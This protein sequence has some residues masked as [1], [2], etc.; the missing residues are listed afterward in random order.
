MAWVEKD[1]PE[2]FD[3][4]PLEGLFYLDGDALVR[5]YPNAL[6]AGY[7]LPMLAFPSGYECEIW[8]MGDL[9]NGAM[10][11]IFG[12]MNLPL[13][14]SRDRAYEQAVA[15]GRECGYLTLREGEDALDIWGMDLREHYR[16]TY[17]QEQKR[18]VNVEWLPLIPT[19]G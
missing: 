11:H 8:D 14:D 3:Q 2:P 17:D 10:V 19:R 13:F 18:I 5:H 15:I 7:K 4:Q 12:E 9:K 16:I 1:T 6:L